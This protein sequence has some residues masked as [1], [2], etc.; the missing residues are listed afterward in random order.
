MPLLIL[1]I[2]SYRSS[3]EP[4]AVLSWASQM[5]RQYLFWRRPLLD[6]CIANITRIWVYLL[7][8]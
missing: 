4:D 8:S 3:A 2:L 5:C 6:T 1:Q 7:V